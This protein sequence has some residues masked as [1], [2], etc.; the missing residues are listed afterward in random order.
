LAATNISIS[1][2][3]KYTEK[4]GKETV[5]T[6]VAGPLQEVYMPGGGRYHYPA[7]MHTLSVGESLDLKSVKISPKAIT[8]KPG[9]AKKIDVTL[10]RKEGFNQT[11]TLDVIFRHLGSVFG[12]PLPPGIKVDEK[13]SQ[14]L[15]TGNNCKGTIVLRAAP[16]AKPVDSQQI[17]VMAHVSVNFVVKMTY[18]GEPLLL[19]VTPK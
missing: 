17:A 19:T 6:A 13:A 3:G 15:L 9:E 14:T 2:R 10:D 11:V 16:D 4:S 12:N 8:L 7:E 1:G 5:L 18:C